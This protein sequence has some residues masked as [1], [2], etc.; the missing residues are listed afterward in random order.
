[1]LH[2]QCRDSRPTAHRSCHVCESGSRVLPPG[3]LMVPSRTARAPRQVGAG[4]P[5]GWVAGV[6]DL[7]HARPFMF[8]LPVLRQNPHASLKTTETVLLMLLVVTRS[9]SP[10]PSR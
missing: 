1:M 8:A 10:S 3:L 5:S 9:A 2:P 4:A 7:N 6:N